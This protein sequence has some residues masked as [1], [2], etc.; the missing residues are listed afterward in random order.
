MTT[1]SDPQAAAP[2]RELAAIMFSDI[3]GYTAI[4]GR[5]EQMAIRALAEHRELLRNL[6]PRFSG[7]MLGEIGDGTLSSF[8]SASE[9]VNC[10]RELQSAVRHSPGLQLRVGIHLGEVLFTGDNAWGDGVNIASR[11][12]AL[13][14]PGSI[15]VSAAVYD[16]IRNKPGMAVKSLG[17]RNLKNVSRPIGLYLLADNADNQVTLGSPIWMS[18]RVRRTAVAVVGASVLVAVTYFAITRKFVVENSGNPSATRPHDIRSIAVLPLDNYSGDPNQEYFADGMT[19]ELTTD[20]AIISQL[21]VISRGSVM[22]FKGDRRPPTPQI[23]KLLNVDAVLEGSVLRVGDK[24]RVTAQLIDAPAN[25]HLWAGSYERESRDVLA[26]QDELASAIAKEI[27]IELTPNEQARLTR[28]LVVNPQSHD[29]YLKGRYF[30]SAP[31]DENLKKSIA[32]FKEA[33]RLDPNFAP[34]YSGLSDVYDWAG[35]NEGFMT[36]TEAM[37]KTRETALRA[38]QLDDQSAEAHASIAVFK[39]LYEFDW[40]GSESEFHRAF[41][42]NPNYAYAHDQLGLTLAQQGRLEEALAEGTRAAELDPLSP[43]ILLDNIFALVW[44]GKYRPAMELADKAADLDPAFFMT[45]FAKGWIHI[46]AG[47]V[48]AAIP[49]LQKAD[50]IESPSW[51]A[52]W[53]GYAYGASGDR[54]KAMT[55]I[56]EIRRKSVHGYVPPFNLAIVY[57]G[58]GNQERAMDYLEQAYSAHSQWL[59]W[60]KMDRIYDPLRKEPRFVALMKKL[61]FAT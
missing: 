25:K 51:T 44:E 24:V 41:A 18:E 32:Q 46:A 37:A 50:K 10:A 13:S 21:R 27:N 30:F 53:L 38:L 5:D 60:L 59:A 52:A 48:K 31:S 15:C 26:L 61:N 47:N 28:A 42:L 23:A 12:H 35:F 34:A 43:Q 9:A 20:L 7:R 39:A 8:R 54:I 36:S 1:P 55:A 19:D 56:D 49:D 57:L 16:Q 11:I 29:A 4:M 17:Q 2:R 6:L 33:V 3:V 45:Q 14:P 22:Q 58:M 40:A